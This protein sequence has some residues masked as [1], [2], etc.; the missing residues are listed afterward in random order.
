MNREEAETLCA[1]N[2]AEHPDRK[3]AQWRVQELPDGTWTVLKIGLAPTGETTPEQ[4][5]DERPPTAD[6]PRTAAMQN[7]GP[8]TGLAL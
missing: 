5:A 7:L 8:H 3:V 6:D 2:A 1:R 4:R